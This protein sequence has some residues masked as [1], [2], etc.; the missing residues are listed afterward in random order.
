MNQDQQFDALK[1]KIG[2]QG[3]VFAYQEPGSGRVMLSFMKQL[4]TFPETKEQME[5]SVKQVQESVEGAV[6]QFASK[7]NSKVRETYFFKLFEWKPCIELK[8]EVPIRP[9]ASN[10]VVASSPKA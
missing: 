1:A 7:L 3:F 10:E 9:A 4:N 6:A 8:I 2:D 5:K